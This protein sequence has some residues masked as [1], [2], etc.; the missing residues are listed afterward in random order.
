[1]VP[2]L[3]SSNFFLGC[4]V[5]PTCD[6]QKNTLCNAT[7]QEIFYTW[8]FSPRVPHPGARTCLQKSAAPTAVRMILVVV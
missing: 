3:F 5:H 6:G 7:F 1:M 2:Q 8:K 4:V